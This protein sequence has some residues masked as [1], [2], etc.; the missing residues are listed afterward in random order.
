MHPNF[1]GSVKML[2]LRIHYQQKYRWLLLWLS[3]VEL[4]SRG[5][6]EEV[7]ATW[8]DPGRVPTAVAQVG[9]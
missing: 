9:E 7:A 6:A 1:G 3:A 8:P 2:E 4:E 5:Q